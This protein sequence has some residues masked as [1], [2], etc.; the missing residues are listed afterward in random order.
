MIA[1]VKRDVVGASDEVWTKRTVCG[2][3]SYAVFGITKSTR[4]RW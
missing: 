1:L 4:Q 3:N 2:S